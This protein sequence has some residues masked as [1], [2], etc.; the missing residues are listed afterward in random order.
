MRIGVRFT[1]AIPLPDGGTYRNEGM[2][3]ARMRMGR[4]TELRVFLDTERVVEL[5]AALGTPA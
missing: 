4:M 5:D 3:Y 2:E 1:D